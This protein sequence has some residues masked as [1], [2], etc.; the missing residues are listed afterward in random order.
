MPW[1]EGGLK[2]Q[3]CRAVVTCVSLAL[4]SRYLM[5]PWRSFLMH[6]LTLGIGKK[7]MS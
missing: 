6:Q 1:H 5:A 4:G 2:V 7:R 3:Q